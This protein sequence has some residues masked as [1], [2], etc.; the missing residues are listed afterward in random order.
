MSQNIVV[1]PLFD[2]NTRIIVRSLFAGQRINLKAFDGAKILATAPLV[3]N[4]GSE[5][6]AVLFRYGA[7]VLLNLDP[8]EEISFLEALKLLV[9][10]P[11][12]KP[13]SEVTDIMIDP[14]QPEQ[15]GDKYIR[16]RE[17]T[18]EYVQV[19][20]DV[21]AKSVT[22]SFYE[23]SIA[24]IFDRI[25]PMAEELSRKGRT[26]RKTREL[27]SHIGQALLVQSKMIGRVQVEEKPDLLWER[28]DLERFYL[29]LEN[30]YELPER[31]GI[32]KHKLELIHQTAETLL[33]LLQDKRTFHVE[34][35]I[36]I[37]IVL[38]LVLS[39][40]SKFH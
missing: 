22:L 7:V 5:G 32:L 29:H 10:D 2:A 36:V 34:W 23:A 16:L 31:L 15:I 27:L 30:E 17:S 9:S 3:V 19:L 38:E 37:L 26:G 21:L 13:E 24:Q 4:A 6:Y 40:F 20:A 12:E 25:E 1:T 18:V 33:G 28:P 39:I 8:L 14:T 11:F 35:Y